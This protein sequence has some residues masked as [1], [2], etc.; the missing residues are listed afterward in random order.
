LKSSSESHC[1]K[2]LV[3]HAIN[4]QSSSLGMPFSNID[5]NSYVIDNNAKE[6]YYG[7]KRK[8]VCNLYG[9]QSIIQAAGIV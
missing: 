6:L 5:M 8:Y 9:E 2:E 7:S 1:H 4:L 3:P